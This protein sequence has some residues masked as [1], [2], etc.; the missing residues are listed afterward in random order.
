MEDLGP[1]VAPGVKQIRSK[2]GPKIHP[3][4]DTPQAKRAAQG[5][6]KFTVEPEKKNE[7]WTRK[8]KDEL[9]FERLVKK[10]TK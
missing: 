7:N 3:A 2:E 9:L 8:N 10:W 6:G 1:E 5:K 4:Y